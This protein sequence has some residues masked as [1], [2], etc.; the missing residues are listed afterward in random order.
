MLSSMR[1]LSGG[2][3]HVVRMLLVVFI[4]AMLAALLLQIAARYLMMHILSTRGWKTA[5]PLPK[6]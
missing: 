6:H 5:M 2:I 1:S 4:T 3:N